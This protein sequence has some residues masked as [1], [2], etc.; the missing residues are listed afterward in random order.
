MNAISARRP[1]RVRPQVRTCR[2]PRGGGRVHGLQHDPTQ[3]SGCSRVAP[4]PATTMKALFSVAAMP[5]PPGHMESTCRCRNVPLNA[6]NDEPAFYNKPEQYLRTAAEVRALSSVLPTFSCAAAL[7]LSGA[8]HAQPRK[9][10]GAVCHSTEDHSAVMTRQPTPPTALPTV[11]SAVL[12]CLSQ[13]FSLTNFAALH[14]QLA[15]QYPITH[16]LLL[17]LGIGNTAAAEAECARKRVG[18][19]S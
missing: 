4:S 8:C 11:A 14:E 17:T 10:A 9:C 6:H 7:R 16:E 3:Q 1:P 19:A 5:C 18:W 2:P 13:C 15:L 12:A